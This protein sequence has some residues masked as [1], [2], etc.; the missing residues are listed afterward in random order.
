MPNTTLSRR[1]TSLFQP[2]TPHV[3]RISHHIVNSYMVASPETGHWVLVDAGLKTSA[4]HIVKA[5][6]ERFG[7]GTQPFAII[8]T[9]G[10]FDHVGALPKLLER[11]NDVP[12]YAHRLEMPYLTGRAKYPPPEPTVG[13]GLMAV[14]SRFFTR[15]PIDITG[16]VRALPDNGDVPGLLPNW[17][18]IHTPGHSPGHVSLFEETDGVLIA[19]D[20]FVTTKQE[21]AAAVLMQRQHVN[22][23]P[24][25][26]TPD[27]RAA[28]ESVKKLAAFEPE[29][30]ATGHGTPMS[31]EELAQQLLTLS[32][33][34]DR[35]AVPRRGRYVRRAAVMD[36]HGVVSVPPPVADP[37]ARGAAIALGT[38]AVGLL[39]F[40]VARRRRRRVPA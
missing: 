1:N 22:G 3:A 32:R 24:A 18:W 2:I 9:H 35:T 21:S 30:A 5:A 37:V 39:G 14:M 36:E 25:Y 27:W 28:K 29:I 4:N 10:H 38:V 26:F 11:W 40:F 15:G 12:V 7:T 8:L 31:G 33:T 19:G 6:E 16:R 20:A 17:R 23:P 34:F 13:G